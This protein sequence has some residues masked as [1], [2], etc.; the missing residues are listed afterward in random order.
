MKVSIVIPCYDAAAFV[1][2]TI[3]SALA[4]THP[5]VEVVVVDDAST[6]G[7]WQVIERYRD[8]VRALRLEANGGGSHARNRGAALARGDFLMFLDSDDVIAPDT[9]ACLVA[10]IRDR[11]GATAVC[12]W[13]RL[14]ERKGRW[15]SAPADVPLPDPAADPLREWLRLRWVPP[16]AVLWRR[17][18][19]ERTG[20]WD[21][22]I[23]YNDDGELMMRSFVQGARLVLAPCGVARYR[24]HG[25]SRITVGTDLTSERR[26]RS[27]MRV[28]EKLSSAL[29]ERGD[30]DAYAVPIGTQYQ[31][32]AMYGF[33]NSHRSLARECIRLGRVRA[34]RRVV[35][36]SL[37]GRLLERVL[38]LERKERLARLLARG[39]VATHGR[40]Q[41]LRRR[42][43][44]A[45]RPPGPGAPPR[46]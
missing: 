1:A 17:D 21:E 13:E 23:S 33:Q 29:E 15:T 6:D 25:A 32:L 34:G 2:E 39:G 16:C 18:V 3:E 43:L 4:Q 5:E 12:R 30:A 11:P 36:P 37:A 41:F 31:L 46:G 27:G 28:L 19:Y 26:L 22:T 9:V 44:A 14:A 35:S 7:S 20:G 42:R 8:R 38:G 40:R 45:L 24:F 10:A